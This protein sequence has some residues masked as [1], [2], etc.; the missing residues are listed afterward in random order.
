LRGTDEQHMP[1]AVVVAAR[2]GRTVEQAKRVLDPARLDGLSSPASY[3]GATISDL[4]ED[5]ARPLD[6]LVLE[7][8]DVAAL[9]AYVL[10][11]LDHRELYVF[12]HR[13]GLD[14]EPEQRLSAIGEALRLSRDG[15]R[16]VESNTLSKLKHPPG[17]A[18]EDPGNRRHRAE[19]RA[20][21]PRS[22]HCSN[23][24]VG[25]MTT[26]QPSGHTR[27]APISGAGPDTAP[28][29]TCQ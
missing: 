7:Q 27:Q 17:H 8:L 16:Q 21:R 15:V 23:L 22:C 20:G 14:G 19:T 11:C 12:S 10:A 13:F 9:S 4:I 1:S 24:H 28:T 3:E 5:R 18:A 26:R 25:R 2:A 29:R 6:E